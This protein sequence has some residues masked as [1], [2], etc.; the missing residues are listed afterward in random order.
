MEICGAE[1]DSVSRSI[2][3]RSSLM[4]DRFNDFSVNFGIGEFGIY[5]ESL[6]DH[7]KDQIEVAD[8]AIN[9]SQNQSDCQPCLECPDCRMGTPLHLKTPPMSYDLNQIKSDIEFDLNLTGSTCAIYS[10]PIEHIDKY[11]SRNSLA[12]SAISSMSSYQTPFKH[13]TL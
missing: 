1:L 4:I 8:V 2:S 10:N 13:T 7:E 3:A 12:D 11:C 9:Q 6:L 5:S